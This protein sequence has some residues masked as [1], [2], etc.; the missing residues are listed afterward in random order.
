MS[1][2]KRGKFTERRLEKAH[3]LAVSALQCDENVLVTG[4]YDETIRVWGT[5]TS[6]L[7]IIRWMNLL[8]QKSPFLSRNRNIDIISH[9][10]TKKKKRCF[11]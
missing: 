3:V 1:N 10:K 11:C 8:E 5:Y 2:W 6:F 9:R 7:F 4:S